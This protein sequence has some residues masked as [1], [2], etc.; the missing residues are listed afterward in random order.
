MAATRIMAIHVGKSGNAQKAVS[1]VIDYVENPEKT[2][3]KQL[4]SSFQCNPQIA[5]TEFMFLRGQYLH[6]TGRSQGKNEVVAYHV[7]Q[8]FVPGEITPEEANRLGYE[9]AKRFTKGKHAF[10]VC[11]HIDKAHIHNHIV[12]SSTT[13]D[14]QRKFRDFFRSGRAVKNLSDT[15][16]IENGFSII[17]NPGNSGKTYDE[18]LGKEKKQS[19]R[20]ILRN[21]IDEALTQRPKTLDSLFDILIAEGYE[22]KGRNSENP[23]LRR[24]GEK[25]FVRMDTLGKE[26]MPDALNSVILGYRS[27]SGSSGRADRNDIEIPKPAGNLL[28]DIQEKLREGKGAG[29]EKWAT[30]YNLK[31]IAQ[32]VIFLQEHNLMNLDAL[33]AKIKETADRNAELQ[34]KI[35]K[36]ET[37]MAEIAVMRGQII[38]YAKTRQVYIDYRKNGY[39]KKFNAE[40]AEEIETHKA[41]KNYFDEQQLKKLPTIK[42]LQKE[43]ADLLAEKKSAY[44]EYRKNREEWKSLVTAKSNL[45]QYLGL[46]EKPKKEKEYER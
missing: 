19:H 2:D 3:N 18:W 7:R 5:G 42:E 38:N 25:R 29:Y 43:Y 13:L 14:C 36:A 15:I 46:K 33:T 39:S 8:S 35:K 23:S 21:T 22:I 32:T 40:H 12:W 41:A 31:Q 37:R 27:E 45:T 28:I 24:E 34:E 30:T 16:C 1:R 17:E 9:F 10:V 11:T 20:D 44:V 4:V 6:N 26:Y